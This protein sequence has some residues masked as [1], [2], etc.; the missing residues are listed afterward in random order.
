FPKRERSFSRNPDYNKTDSNTEFPKRE[1][2]FSRVSKDE[3]IDNSQRNKGLEKVFDT[4][5]HFDKEKKRKKTEILSSKK[6]TLT[7]I[8]GNIRL[9]RFISNA[10]VCSRREAD[11]LISQGMVMVN[12]KVVTELGVKV[13]LKDVV[14][15]D[16]KTLKPEKLSY[17][18][19]NKPKDFIT[20]ME[21]PFERK[22][23]MNLLE[24][25]VEQRIYP[26]G[27]LDRNTTGLLLF[28]NDGELA[29]TLTHPSSMVQK[30][31]YVEIN[32]PIKEED[33]QKLKDGITLEDGFIKLDDVQIVSPDRQGIG[34]EVHSGKN[35]IIRRIFEQLEYEITKLDRVM[36]A[37]LTKLNLSRGKWR[38]LD[39][40]EINMLKKIKNDSVSL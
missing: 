11:D 2:S 34:I 13:T 9:N 12:G 4:K 6:N 24:S 27:R 25:A 28:T 40:K 26:V 36:Y 8:S 20:T 39:S 29:K 30:I 38:H 22:T 17:I 5:D 10:G 37:G 7:D 21:D 32:K 33:F 3:V 18:L 35:R 23:V 19:L 1:R 31:Y 16:G 15:F 14:I